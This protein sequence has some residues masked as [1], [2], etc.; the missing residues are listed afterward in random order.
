MSLVVSVKKCVNIAKK[1]RDDPDPA[2]VVRYDG[3][4][5]GRTSTKKGTQS[6]VWNEVLVI[7][8]VNPQGKLELT[9]MDYRMKSDK[10]AEKAAAAGGEIKGNPI[11]VASVNIQERVGTIVLQLRKTSEKEKKGQSS[12]AGELH[13]SWSFEISETAFRKKLEALRRAAPVVMGPLV[14]AEDILSWTRPYK[15]AFFLLAL[16]WT[17]A[18]FSFVFAVPL[19]ACAGALIHTFRGRSRYGPE[20]DFFLEKLLPLYRDGDEDNFDPDVSP[21]VLFETYF[22]S[23]HIGRMTVKEK[24]RKDDMLYHTY[25]LKLG[26]LTD[27]LDSVWAVLCRKDINSSNLV[28]N[29]LLAWI[30]AELVGI[31]PPVEYVLLGVT[32][33]CFILYPLHK[34]FPKIADDYNVVGFL[35]NDGRKNLRDAK[36]AEQS[37]RIVFN[38]TDGDEAREARTDPKNATAASSN[39]LSASATTLLELPCNEVLAVSSE[40]DQKRQSLSREVQYEGG[41]PGKKSG[42]G[43]RKRAKQRVE[44]VP[45]TPWS[46]AAVTISRSEDRGEVTYFKVEAELTSGEVQ[47][48]W[49]RYSQFRSLKNVCGKL[50]PDMGNT[51]FPG[52]TMRKCDG[53]SLINRQKELDRF[54]ADLVSKA[55]SRTILRMPIERFLGLRKEA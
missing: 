18:H 1:G 21:A 7:D 25:Q 13:I 37:S 22:T 11:A 6:P 34:H 26:H 30:L 55:Q 28:V 19:L 53:Q 48:A 47:V 38:G 40:K 32:W 24:R 46:V 17:L 29:C 52:K 23:K 8:D 45:A 27:T 44:E 2:V 12:S 35:F 31:A 14:E 10:A 4:P 16:T 9:V 36:R 54:V 50:L 43:S 3:K 33:G 15:T 39:G 49:H 5:V 41:S 20:Y 51:R 42:K